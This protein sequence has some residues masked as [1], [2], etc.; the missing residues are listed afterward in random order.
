MIIPRYWL[1]TYGRWSFTVASLSV[2]NS[3]PDNLRDMVVSRN[4]FRHSLEAF[5]FATY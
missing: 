3:L 2:W 5:L 4:D 1:S